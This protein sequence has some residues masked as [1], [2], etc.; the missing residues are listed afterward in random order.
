MEWLVAA[1]G[2]TVGTMASPIIAIVGIAVGYNLWRKETGWALIIGVV[3]LVT[4]AALTM[5]RQS[6]AGLTLRP[7]TTFAAQAAAMLAWAAIAALI[8][9]LWRKVAEVDPSFE[10]RLDE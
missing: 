7:V 1:A 4:S 9:W 6:D 3:G 8:L 5:M 10:K 2:Y